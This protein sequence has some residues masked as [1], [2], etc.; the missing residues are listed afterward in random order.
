MKIV[1]CV[2]YSFLISLILLGFI[3]Y[4]QFFEKYKE[5]KLPISY[6][7]LKVMNI[8]KHKDFQAISYHVM[9]NEHEYIMLVSTAYSNVIYF[10]YDKCNYCKVYDLH[11]F[12]DFSF[13]ILDGLDSNELNKS[14]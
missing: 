10:H 11:D 5:I 14:K 3:F 9:I 13:S 12:D 4:R 1:Y 6:K 7:V 8:K 2:I